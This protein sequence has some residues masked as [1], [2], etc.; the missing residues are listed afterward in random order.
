[1]LAFCAHTDNVSVIIPRRIIACSAL[2]DACMTAAVQDTPPSPAAP[3]GQAAPARQAALPS[4]AGPV[5]P[6]RA[7]AK[8]ADV[9]AN[10]ALR[11]T[12][13]WPS[14]EPENP[15]TQV[16]MWRKAPYARL[17]KNGW[18]RIYGMQSGRNDKVEL[19]LEARG[20][21]QYT[22]EVPLRQVQSCLIRQVMKCK[23][24]SDPHALASLEVLFQCPW[25]TH[26]TCLSHSA[27]CSQA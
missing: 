2:S 19:I 6:A 14:G 8:S 20:G 4:P 15:Y 27:H 16:I 3:A 9:Y 7:N 24:S 22:L 10:N 26:I 23:T 18:M 25:Y 12:R 5:S 17:R 11:E 21:N 13:V 1:M